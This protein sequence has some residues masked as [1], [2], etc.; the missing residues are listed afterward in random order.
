[1]SKKDPQK[2][3]TVKTTAHKL[4]GFSCKLN[5]D[6][7]ALVIVFPLEETFLPSKS[8]G[9]TLLVASTHGVRI[10]P[11]K[12]NFMNVRI[13]MNAF[14]PIKSNSRCID[15]NIPGRK[16]KVGVDKKDIPKI[17]ELIQY[18]RKTSGDRKDAMKTLRSLGH[19]GGVKTASIY[20][21]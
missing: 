5:D 1:M 10:C 19:W 18:L 12:I 2:Y 15:P 3:H 16:N 20:D 13:M 11:L 8:S 9:Q 17:K 21:D 14:I 6:E 7:N 4:P